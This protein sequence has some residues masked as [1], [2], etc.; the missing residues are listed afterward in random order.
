MDRGSM[1]CIRPVQNKQMT[2]FNW[3]ICATVGKIKEQKWRIK[4]FRIKYFREPKLA[5]IVYSRVRLTFLGTQ[6][7]YGWNNDRVSSAKTQIFHVTVT[8]KRREGFVLLVHRLTIHPIMDLTYPITERL[9]NPPQRISYSNK[10][11]CLINPLSPSIKLQILL[12][13]LYTFLTEVKGRS[14]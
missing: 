7:N 13:C 14:C 6:L 5:S 3:R 10:S 2:Y 12:L 9:G 4:F 8:Y 11:S 1:F